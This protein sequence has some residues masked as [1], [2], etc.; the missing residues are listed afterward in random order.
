MYQIIQKHE[1]NFNARKEFKIQCFLH[2]INDNTSRCMIY[3]RQT[4]MIQLYILYIL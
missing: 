4:R 1:D 2:S 3:L